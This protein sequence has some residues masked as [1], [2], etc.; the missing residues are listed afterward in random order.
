MILNR[1]D[2][3]DK[4]K[5]LNYLIIIYSFLIPIS[6]AGIGILSV[7]IL[8]VWI[9]KADIKNDIKFFLQN[10]FTLL[11]ITFILYSFIAILWSSNLGEGLNYAIR[12]CYYLPM[13]IIAT[14]L[15]KEYFGLVISTFL[16][17]MMISEVLSYGMFFELIEWKNSSSPFATPFMNHLQYSTFVVFTSLFLLNHI[18]YKKNR[19]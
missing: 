15:K 3:L 8:L 17:S 18:L 16:F 6:R 5:I 9:F 12:Y 11:F 10:R 14:H 4:D 7:L 19:C 13:F 1:V 2:T